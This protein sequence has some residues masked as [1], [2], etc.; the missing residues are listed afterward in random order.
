MTVHGREEVMKLPVEQVTYVEARGH[1][2]VAEIYTRTG[3]TLQL[4]VTESITV[5]EKLLCPLALSDAIGR[6]FAGRAAF[7]R[8]AGRRSRWITAV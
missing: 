5:L 4:E 8:S 1:G 3:E 6:T 2:C 7:I